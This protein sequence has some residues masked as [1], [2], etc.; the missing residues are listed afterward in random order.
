MPDKKLNLSGAKEILSSEGPKLNLSGALDILKKKDQAP[1][2][3]TGGFGSQLGSQTFQPT[4]AFIPA[5][6]VGTGVEDY[7]K[8]QKA[9]AQ[10]EKELS[11]KLQSQQDIYYQAQGKQSA[12]SAYDG[13]Q[14]SVKTIDDE[15]SK[16]YP[17]EATA[18]SRTQSGLE[19][20]GKYKQ[21][22]DQLVLNRNQF[23][24]QSDA[25]LRYINPIIESD[26]NSALNKDGLKS[27]TRVTGAGFEVPDEYKIDSYAKAYSQQNGVSDNGTFKRL[28][29]DKL[30][31]SVSFNISKP[32]IQKEFDVL[33]K[34]E[35][36]VNPDQAIQKDYL[37]N[38]TEAQKI[39]TNLSLQVQSLNNDIKTKLNDGSK[40]LSLEYKP[41]LEAISSDYKNQSASLEL[42]SKEL[43]ESYKSGLISKENYDIAFNN[44][45]NELTTLNT[46]YQQ[47]FDAIS[48]EFLNNQ[49][50]L[51]SKY[52]KRYKRQISEFTGMAEQQ[53][54]D[55]SSRYGK[56]YQMSNDLRKKYQSI[57]SKATNKYLTGQEAIKSDLDRSFVPNNLGL[58]FA[59]NLFIGLGSGIKSISSMY[60]FDAGY[61][62]GDYMEN[63]IT[64]SSPEIKSISDL[65]DATKVQSSVGRMLGGMAPALGASALAGAVTKSAPTAVRLLTTGLANYISETAQIGGG[66][67]DT[68]FQKTGNIADAN[69]A[70]K[71]AVDANMY[72]LPLYALDGL[73]FL[74][75]ITLGIKNTF[76]RAGAKAGIETLTELPQEYFQGIFEDLAISDKPI[77]DT[78]RN[79]TLEKFNNTALN[80]IPTTVLLGG[81]GTAFNG[82]KDEIAKIQGKS[83]AA[84]YDLFDLT[85]TAKQQF[86]YDTI[87]RRGDVFAKAYVSSLFNSG[88]INEQ[89]LES[90]SKMIED[91][92]KTIEESKKVGLNKVQSKVYAALK[93]DY[94]QAKNEFDSEQDEAS[95][96]LYKAKMSSAEKSLNDFL[97]GKKPDAVVLTLANNEQY[98]YSFETLNSIIDEGGDLLNQIIDGDVKVG[99]LTDKSNPKA[100]ALSDKLNKIKKE[101]AVQEPSTTS[102]VSP[103]IEGG[104]VVQEGGEGVGQGVEG[105]QAPQAIVQEEVAP[106][107]VYFDKTLEGKNKWVIDIQDEGLK[108]QFEEDQEDVL[109]R[110]KGE[111][112]QAFNDWFKSKTEAPQAISPEEEVARLREQEKAEYAAMDNPND[113]RK[114]KEIYDR[115]DKL[116]TPLLRKA[117]QEA[118]AEEVVAEPV[119]EPAKKEKNK[120]DKEIELLE[121][122]L[123][124]YEI[125]F[126]N[127]REEIENLKSELK[128]ERE[129][130]KKAIADVRKSNLSRAEKED[131]IEDL[132]Y[133]LEDFI[134]TNDSLVENN[135]EDMQEAKKEIAK[136][137]KK[138][139]KLNETAVE[140]EQAV[141]QETPKNKS[142]ST[143]NKS[144]LDDLKSRVT[145]AIKSAVIKSAERAIVTLKSILPDFDIV[146]HEDEDSYN[147]ATGN[148]N[149]RG[150][151]S[152]SVNPDG[153]YTGTIDINLN[154]ANERT[155]AHEVAHAVL[156]KLFGEN[157][158]LF[159]AFRFK[160]SKIL[161]SSRNKELVKFAN[162]Y[163]TDVKAEEYLVELTSILEQ[164]QDT[165]SP[166]VLQQIAAYINDIVSKLTN[167]AIKP[168][169]NVKDTKDII[170]FFNTVSKSIREGEAISEDGTKFKKF[171]EQVVKGPESKSK[172]QAENIFTGKESAPKFNN[173]SDAAKWLNDWA[174][175]NK[176][177]SENVSKVSDE[178]FVNK[179]VEHTIKELNAWESVKGNDYVGFYEEDIPN[180]L[181]PGLQEFAE[182][183]YGRLL[184]NEEIALYHMVSG[185]ASP[186][187]DP[188][189]DS[190]KGLEV[191]DK[192][193]MSSGNVLSGYTDKQATIWEKNELG[194]KVDT[195]KL[196]FDENGNPIYSQV[197]PKYAVQSLNKFKNVISYFGGLKKAINW[198]LSTHS[199]EEISK[200]MG[201]PLSGPKKLDAH[202]NLSKEN[203]GFGIF[204]FTGP[205]LGSYILNRIG[206]YST[207][208]K[209]MWYARTMARLTGEPLVDSKGKALNEP[210]K[211]KTKDG[212]RKRLL[213]DKAWD[214]VAKKLNI[215]PS[216]VQQKMWD[217]EKRLYEKLGTIEKSGYAS[218]G[219]F[220]G[221][222]QIQGQ[223]SKSQKLEEQVANH[224]E[225]D[226]STYSLTEGNLIGKPAASVSIFNERRLGVPTKNI[227]TKILSDF[228]NKNSDLY[229]GNEDVLALGTW[230]D[231]KVGETVIDVV[232]ALPKK[233]A[234]QLGKDYNQK[235]VF[236]L[237]NLEDIETGGT[238]EVIEGL[239]PEIERVEDIRKILGKSKSQKIN[240]EVSKEGKGDPTISVRS[241]IVQ[242]AAQNLKEGKIRN[243]EYRA[244]A[245]QNS[246]IGPIT[247]F[248]APA[249]EEQIYN[250]LDSR[251]KEKTNVPVK[252]GTEVGLRLDI[253]AYTNK[254]TWVVSVH[255]GTTNAGNAIS[256]TNVAR[257]VDVTFRP[258]PRGALGIAAGK[259]KTTIGRM[260]GKW[261][262]IEGD[263]LE[264]KG[265]NAKKLVEDIVNNPAWVQIGM[266]PFRHSYFYDRSSD[267]GRPVMKADEVIQV[268]GLV[269]AKNPVYGNWTD[270]AFEVKGLL[271]SSGKVVKFQ[272]IE[273]ED[274]REALRVAGMPYLENTLNVLSA[275]FGMPYKVIFDESSDETGYIDYDNY[276][277]PT[278]IV[279]TA[280]ATNET[281]LV[282]YGNIFI[283]Q[284]K[285]TNKNLFSGLVKQVLNTKEGQAE[286]ELAKQRYENDD[287]EDQVQQAVV[288]LLAKYGKNQ[289]DP[290]TGIHKA[291]KKI[292]NTILEFLSNSFNVNINE[293]PAS[294]TMEQL[295]KILSHPNI[296]INKKTYSDEIKGEIAEEA[297]RALENR[298]IEYSVIKKMPNPIFIDI[299]DRKYIGDEKQFEKFYEGVIDEVDILNNYKN[300]QLLVDLTNIKSQISSYDGRVNF[301]YDRYPLFTKLLKFISSNPRIALMYINDAVE[302]GEDIRKYLERESSLPMLDESLDNIVSDIING[303]SIGKTIGLEPPPMYRVYS[304]S[305]DSIDKVKAKLESDIEGL[306]KAIENP[307]L[308]AD[309]YRRSFR[310]SVGDDTYRIVGTYSDG[311]ISIEFSSDKYGMRDANEA[312]FFKVLPKVID[313]ISYMY[314]DVDY[315]TISFYPI[316]GESS[317]GQDLRLKG[318]NIFAKRLFGEF[319]LLAE[320]DN[321]TIIPI[322]EIFKN[323][324]LV[325]ERTYSRSQ[326]IEG[327]EQAPQKGGP[328]ARIKQAIEKS[329]AGK[330]EVGPVSKPVEFEEAEVIPSEKGKANL[331]KSLNAPARNLEKQKQLSEGAGNFFNK[332]KRAAIDTKYDIAKALTKSKTP[333]GEV[334]RAA[335][336]NA[337]G[338]TGE[339]SLVIKLVNSQIFDKLSFAPNIKLKVI[340]DNGNLVETVRSER[341]LFDVFLDA[342]RIINIDARIRDKF[343]ELVSL[344]R[345]LKNGIKNESL[346]KEEQDELVNQ[347]SQLKEY[348]GRRKALDIK[349]PDGQLQMIGYQDPDFIYTDKLINLLK[350]DYAPI[351]Y[352]H[353]DGKTQADAEL[354]LSEIKQ[355]LPELYK[356]F[357]KMSS[358]YY[359]N[360]RFLLD[361]SLENGLI[362]KEV[363]DELWSYNYIPTKFIQHFIESELAIDNPSKAKKLSAS[364]KNLTGGSEEDVITNY[365]YILELYT[366]AT[367]RRIFDNRAAIKLAEALGDINPN[368][369]GRDSKFFIQKPN[370]KD[371]NGNPTYSD[372]EQGYDYIKFMVDGVENRIIAPKQ[373]VSIWYDSEFQI[374]PWQESLAG[375]L[376]KISLVEFIK[377][378]FTK[379]NPVFGIL[380][381][382]LDAPQAL[383]STKAYPDFFLGSVLLA[384]DYASVA[385]DVLSIVRD[386]KPTKFFLEAV[387]AGVFSDFLSTE[388]DLI[389]GEKFTNYDG[390]PN[391][392]N[393]VKYII[394][395][396]NRGVDKT[397]STI[398]KVNEAV[399]YSTRLAVY[400]R[401]NK[402]LIAKF[403]KD[404]NGAEP[405]GRDLENIQ[406][407]SAEQSRIVVDFSVAGGVTKQLNKIFAYLNSTIQVFVSAARGLKNNPWKAGLIT[408]EIG[409]A[410][411]AILAY[412]LGDLSG[413]DD[414]EKK[415]RYKEY[416]KLSTYEKESYFLVWTG[417][418]ERPFLRIPKPP[419]FKGLI[420]IFEQGYLHASRGEDFNQDKM[421]SAFQRDIPFGNPLAELTRN[422]MINAMFKYFNNYDQFRKQNIVKREDE[423]RDYAE[424]KG[425]TELYK[426]IGKA[427]K[428]LGFKEGVSPRRLQEAVRS[429]TGDP[430]KNTWSSLF[431][432][433]SK[434]SVALITGDTKEFDKT[435]EGNVYSSLFRNL[436]FTG[437]LFTK[438]IDYDA[439]FAEQL[440]ED[441]KDEYTKRYIIGNDVY[442][443]RN[444]AKDLNDA[445]KSIYEYLKPR[446]ESK[447]ID[448]E[449]ANRILKQQEKLFGIK[450]APYFYDDIFYEKDNGIKAKMLNYYLSD[451]SNIEANKIIRDMASRKLIT[452]EVV[453]IMNEI[454]SSKRK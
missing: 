190:S 40:A 413:E 289:F 448:A 157:A 418:P 111:A 429:F 298:K 452:K 153:T 297:K 271:D 316:S 12:F 416:K 67:K 313:A 95:K 404:N 114:A 256:Y 13:Y 237:E 322:P 353:T 198:A 41:R 23:E 88:N 437:K 443:L 444:N 374:L 276:G 223:V 183:R 419:L 56:S 428:D 213:A 176:I 81:V 243:E 209:D 224:K 171:G 411:A 36:G 58:Q 285:N 266:N 310:V 251:Q 244:T 142:V 423:I 373:F 254:N 431:D 245:S 323:R 376:S 327:E 115:Y 352:T 21:K 82:V 325:E 252:N 305:L 381:L 180:I 74:D 442:D 91:A 408:L 350:E 282:Q 358:D 253:N 191:F 30:K 49:N 263:T 105:T 207:V 445:K 346:T 2:S 344:S 83:F 354:M 145:N 136:I 188:I 320:D 241:N 125:D 392:G 407:L 127:A 259:S 170:D 238:D 453:D 317:K 267:I 357:D 309:Y 449:Y 196:R 314:S 371:K 229:K 272:K 85:K 227:T 365:Q 302:S 11:Q 261:K 166:T 57:W 356:T 54:A 292:W 399:E 324:P 151:F 435:F 9:K 195:G 368:S 84:K 273:E 315:N 110:T 311:N 440:K 454:D 72:L 366:H 93:L 182:K 187:A 202:E 119:A 280:N 345:Q 342:N 169:E 450:D 122:D 434:G 210:W 406:L 116:I 425:A 178:D 70:A 268:G 242:Q 97:S 260:F 426:K 43:G 235:A 343:S 277:E 393:Q 255:E 391:I 132:K 279:N 328:L 3:A 364:L 108:N 304:S 158:K 249:T 226:G 290:K 274:N 184:T 39:K 212:L 265:E 421:W 333:I 8:G 99:L 123:L 239:K 146:I 120:A 382:L 137:N 18:G 174:N 378:V 156:L 415:K 217:F 177:F 215:T 232:A 4:K 199:Y 291:I 287:Y 386:G 329:R 193:M 441:K 66:I 351:Q 385:K 37:D 28:V 197:A 384:K 286:L 141:K 377:G 62:F 53:I 77:S 214:I 134:D 396:I 163:G 50:E 312:L 61:V 339:S 303:Y 216:A 15:I 51:Y 432:M 295:S 337:K 335:M 400:Y 14:S 397:L 168:F 336:R 331:F 150:N 94:I 167:G 307:E 19:D 409:A 47:S 240:W 300:N 296:S 318:Y 294:T 148:P 35:F 439:S 185:F 262:N 113:E 372:P 321:T 5:P 424:T 250:A 160:I 29:Y 330:T 69:K 222:K 447:D 401:M 236:D 106:L 172:F 402:N 194:D 228:V 139:K 340:D 44:I 427:S 76:V 299:N 26:I 124:S 46:Q 42:K 165:I 278:I 275:K 24:S 221:S 33:F 16:N 230:W 367:Y 73:P 75:D 65:L 370:G 283:N 140:S 109:Y 117:K 301:D 412:S 159:K 86:V 161:T 390:T 379:Y 430:T 100:K 27:F 118:V 10:A 203:G 403:K 32:K 388:N 246:P 306:S 341:Q 48:K 308:G 147:R 17:D 92:N 334:A 64:S 338:Y 192:Y 417:D 220:K 143:K 248:F 422:P 25:A 269:Y 22:R 162:L 138:L 129:R 38:F 103:V 175:K 164:E 201:T 380:Q 389:K 204:G 31:S 101:N 433:G 1:V 264:Q 79:M 102:E 7:K 394:G 332:L 451:M 52:D 98:I 71:K 234:I 144:Q 270:E 383:I 211:Q 359:D 130:I 179:L 405:T 355:Q 288:S 63:S 104:Q 78:F 200:V 205:K 395:R 121:S 181:N 387:R 326:K 45:K 173:L 96:K 225:Y 206:E 131:K 293:I 90:F 247:R 446:V 80:V 89:E 319:S 360:F 284:I 414:E 420:N 186:G 348:L 375:F 398:A 154:K 128:E 20:Y 347:I 155:V 112:V 369:F 258:E 6:L 135:K 189:L 107:N 60:D 257:I 87:L 363:Y 133:E 68:V 349:G 219:F 231:S 149:T 436:G 59:K 281:P 218:E 208:T 126:D 152:Y 233:D 361:K 438:P 34:K 362:T 410:S 55:A